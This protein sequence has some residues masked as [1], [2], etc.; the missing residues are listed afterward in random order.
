MSEFAMTPSEML[1]AVVQ[2]MGD[3]LQQLSRSI[4][5]THHTRVFQAPDI[6]GVMNP[7]TYEKPPE[8]KDM[9]YGIPA[10]D[11][12]NNMIT[13]EAKLSIACDSIRPPFHSE[14]GSNHETIAN[15]NSAFGDHYAE[16]NHHAH[17]QRLEEQNTEMD[18]LQNQDWFAELMVN[19][20]IDSVYG[21]RPIELDPDELQTWYN[22]SI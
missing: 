1:M 10:W 19:H 6:S 17:L 9:D 22:D 15:H 4:A 8:P 13:K 5:R 20:A 11:D 21:E 12:P 18:N 7:W 2:R 3:P 14:V 16:T